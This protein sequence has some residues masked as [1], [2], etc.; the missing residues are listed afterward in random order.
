MPSVTTGNAIL[1]EPTD[2]PDKSVVE[3]KVS[4]FVSDVYSNNEW[5][6]ARKG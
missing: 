6:R 1:R 5:G 4:V 2:R 3:I